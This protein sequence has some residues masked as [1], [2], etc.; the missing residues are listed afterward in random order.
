VSCCGEDF[1]VVKGKEEVIVMNIMATNACT[2]AGG[3]LGMVGWL[4]TPTSGR[5]GLQNFDREKHVLRV[6]PKGTVA[7]GKHDGGCLIFLAINRDVAEGDIHWET[8][9]VR[10][11]GRGF[12]TM[13]YSGVVR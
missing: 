2:L 1:I 12:G 8:L 9:E 4:A 6:E 7:H 5:C 3:E 11:F 10:S 13:A